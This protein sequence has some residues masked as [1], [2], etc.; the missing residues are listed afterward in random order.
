MRIDELIFSFFFVPFVSF[1]CLPVLKCLGFVD[2]V[3]EFGAVAAG[4]FA[5]GGGGG[6]CDGGEGARAAILAAPEDHAEGGDRGGELEV[7]GGG[8]EGGAAV[9]EGVFEELAGVGVGLFVAEFEGQ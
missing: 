3:E 6:F 7:G 1:C 4:I 2:E 8:V 5:E 9:G